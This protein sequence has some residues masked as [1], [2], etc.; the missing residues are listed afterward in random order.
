MTFQEIITALNA[1]WANNGCALIPS[2]DMEM[3]A[4]TFHPET[5]FRALGPNPFYACFV[6]PSRRPGDGRYGLHP[7]RVYRHHQFQVLLKPSPPN[8]QDLVIKSFEKLRLNTKNHDIRFVEDNWKSPTLG[9]AGLGWEVWCDGMEI[10]Q[11]TYFQQMGGITCKPVT[12]ELVYGLERL[13]MYLQDKDDVYDLVWQTFPDGYALTYGDLYKKA[14]ASWSM[15]NFE[16]ANI[17]HL[18]C[19][20]RMAT[21]ESQGLSE[22]GLF[23][24]AYEHCIHASHLF[25][26]LDARGALS[27]KERVSYID[28]VRRLA[29]M[30]LKSHLDSLK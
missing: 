28:N 4:G 8:V 27:D 21:Q 30:S 16:E 22:K 9:A 18:I 26:L 29:Q 25:N 13:A 24:P 5:V 15:Y 11:F 7:N 12:A 19:R 20:F 17:D 1:F 23:L 10:L 3:G 6:Q 2:Y 14:E